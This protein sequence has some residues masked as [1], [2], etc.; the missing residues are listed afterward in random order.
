MSTAVSTLLD[1]LT[2]TGQRLLAARAQIPMAASQGAAHPLVDVWLR[3]DD[4][5]AVLV[6]C[7]GVRQRRSHGT[8]G[9]SSGMAYARHTD[10]VENYGRATRV[11]WP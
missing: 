1:E 11:A 4:P 7:T 3:G 6:L 9:L 5:L 10:V 8:D 2:V